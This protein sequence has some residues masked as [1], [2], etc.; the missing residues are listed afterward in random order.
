MTSN[1]HSKGQPALWGSADADQSRVGK[2]PFAVPVSVLTTPRMCRLYLTLNLRSLTVSA[3]DHR[4][5]TGGG[6]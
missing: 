3:S 5:T 6:Q 1:A 2:A 4:A